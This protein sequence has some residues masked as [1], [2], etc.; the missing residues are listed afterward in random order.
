MSKQRHT[1]WV[2]VGTNNGEIAPTW[3]FA[4][5]KWEDGTKFMDAANDTVSWELYPCEFMTVNETME[6]FKQLQQD[7]ST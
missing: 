6:V 1:A 2:C 7:P 3:F 4:F 5:R